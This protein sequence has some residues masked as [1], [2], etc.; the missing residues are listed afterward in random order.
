ML[1]LGLC[2]A[3]DAG[4]ALV[5]DGHVVGLVQRERWDR[6]KRSALITPDFLEYALDQLGVGWSQIDLVA[7]STC[8]SWPFLFPEPER[9]HFQVDPSVAD[10]IPVSGDVRGAI[11]AS[12][13]KVGEY[14]SALPN[15][16]SRIADGLY[17]EYFSIDPSGLTAERHAEACVEWPYYPGSWANRRTEDDGLPGRIARLAREAQAAVGYSTARAVFDGVAKPAVLVPHHLAHAAYGFYHSGEERAA[18]ATLDNGDVF[19]GSSGYTGGLLVLGEGNHLKVIDFRFAYEGHLYQRIGE[20]IGL[21]H[22]GAAGK[23][24]GLAPY[25]TPDYFDPAL[26]GD[27][28]AIFGERYVRGEKDGR[29]HVMAPVMG[30]AAKAYEADGRA[31]DAILPG[32]D[33][34]SHGARDV[35]V[36][37]T[38]L[39]ATAQT[40]MEESTLATLSAMHRGLAEAGVAVDAAVLSG[41]VALNCPANSRAAR[42][43]AFARVRV[44]PAVDDSGLPLGAAMA[45]VHDL[46]G[47]PRRDVDPDSA[48]IAYL[49]RAFD[50][51]SVDRAI[52]AAGDAVRVE[53]VD[54]PAAA[55]A[56]DLAADNVVAWFEGRSEIGPRALGRRSI[57]A[58]ARAEANWRR[59]NRLKKREEWRPFAPAVLTEKA[60]DWFDGPLPSPHMLFTARIK[61]PDLPAITHV[62]GSAR[63]QT[64]GRECGGYRRVL[65]AFEARTGVPVL[66]N[67]SFNGPGEPIVETPEQAI[68]FLTSSEIDAVYLEGRKL[69]RSEP[70]G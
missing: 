38:R 12:F 59:V 17:G 21:G 16:V 20:T 35:T 48:E 42:E 70:D 53:P 8:Q 47:R 3:H 60:A 57:L 54:D 32:I 27:A 43:T 68:A 44:A 25:G 65:E 13:G 40:L 55:A 11:R 51:A 29:G 15:R 23:L 62:D 36:Q 37:K 19:V 58:D 34:E 10:L 9:F 39:A 30:L 28:F 22:G 50:G 33:P 5:D 67:T 26:I 64:V 18:I 49:G 45:V 6:V 52:A 24:M 1:V 69:V 66:M 61:G 2:V 63:V 7:I 41:G 46:F 31:L 56:E 4:V 14:R